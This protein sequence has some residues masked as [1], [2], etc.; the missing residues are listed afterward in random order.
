MQQ[1]AATLTEHFIGRRSWQAYL[2]PA[3]LQI[4]KLWRHNQRPDIERERRTFNRI[5]ARIP[6]LEQITSQ[7]IGANGIA[8]EWQRPAG[9]QPS[10]AIFYVHGG[11]FVVGSVAAYRPLTHRLADACQLPLLA[12]D[13]SLAPEHPFPTAPDQVL[14]AYRWLCTQYDSQRIIVAGDSAGA[15]L[16][17]SA[18]LKAR[19]EGVPLPAAVVLIAPWVDLTF[20]MP[21]LRRRAHLDGIL[22]LKRLQIAA[23]LYLNGQDASNPF[24][25]PLF[26]NF[27]GF[28]PVFVQLGT[29]DIL[30]EEGHALA[31]RMAQQ[32]VRTYVEVWHGMPH[33]WHLFAHRLSEGKQAYKHVANFIKSIIH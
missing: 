32:G 28:P 12:V 19:E 17:L 33:V 1:T 14:A 13:Y 20:S 5:C 3:I 9:Y 31:R 2:L 24:A 8:C 30:F 16:A 10:A 21:G 18:L 11:G 7:P 26:A 4:Y 6:L 29:H 27:D 22:S 25:S 15:N 23:K